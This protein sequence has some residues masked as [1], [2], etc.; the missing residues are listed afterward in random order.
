MNN[1]PNDKKP[2]QDAGKIFLEELT[3][4]ASAKRRAIALPMPLGV[5]APETVIKAQQGRMGMPEDIVRAAL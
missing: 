5:D 4:P 2:K 1:E 3:A